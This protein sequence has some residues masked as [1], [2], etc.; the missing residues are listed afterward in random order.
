MIWDAINNGNDTIDINRT[1]QGKPGFIVITVTHHNTFSLKT[2]V[3]RSSILYL[4]GKSAFSYR[5]LKSV[6]L[7]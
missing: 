4:S 1:V 5:S 3:P 2:S 6:K 7:Q